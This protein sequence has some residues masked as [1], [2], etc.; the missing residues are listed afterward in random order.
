[1]SKVAKQ[2]AVKTTSG[3]NDASRMLGLLSRRKGRNS[4]REAVSG[5]QPG[6]VKILACHL[7]SPP[8]PID[9]SG[10]TLRHSPRRVF[11]ESTRV[12][13]GGPRL[14]RGLGGRCSGESETSFSS[15][16]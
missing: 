16:L 15:P 6:S 4:T 14:A 1:M 7:R 8:Y 2:A 9:R 3:I 13:R 11:V 5:T 12:G 10:F